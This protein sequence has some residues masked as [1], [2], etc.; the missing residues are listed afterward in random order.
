MYVRVRWWIGD[1][2]GEGGDAEVI[3][4]NICIAARKHKA[5]VDGSG[6]P[7]ALTNTSKTV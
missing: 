2:E 7:L 5:E 6:L 3:Q 1:E 4:P